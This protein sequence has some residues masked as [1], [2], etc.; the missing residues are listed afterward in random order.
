MTTSQAGED[1]TKK[2][3][4]VEEKETKKDEGATSALS[5]EDLIAGTVAA[6]KEQGLLSEKKEEGTISEDKVSELLNSQRAE[7]A[8]AIS[9]EGEKP[10]VDPMTKALLTD[11]KGT[12][13]AIVNYTKNKI[14][15]EMNAK[16]EVSQE[17]IQVATELKKER[18]DIWSDE[19]NSDIFARLYELQPEGSAKDR[20]K[21]AL[22]EYDKF[23]EKLGRGDAKE[24]IAQASSTKSARGSSS[25]SQDT[26]KSEEEYHQEF[27]N[28][29]KARKEKIRSIA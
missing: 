26:P 6:L 7:I 15:E 27:L 28:D 29:R 13:A 18:P 17:E 4:E 10:G 14:V 16:D 5:Q 25:E 3:D 24:R 12:I 21:G 2:E 8:K 19:D 9:G 23:Q 20:V 1:V 22:A 11:T